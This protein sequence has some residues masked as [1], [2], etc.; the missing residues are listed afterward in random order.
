MKTQKQI[1]QESAQN[2]GVVAQSNSDL[3][4]L[5]NY[6]KDAST[7]YES[8]EF[9]AFKEL[10]RR[11]ETELQI[12]INSSTEIANIMNFLEGYEHEEF[13]TIYLRKNNSIIKKTQQSK[14]GTS[15]TV[16]DTRL[17]LKEAIL[18][19]SSAIILCHNH[20]SGELSPSEADKAITQKIKN[21]AKLM[22][23]VV[24][25]HIIIGGK[26]D[27]YSFADNGLMLM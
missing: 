4:K 23:I 18:L 15:G 25:D 19:N 1:L 14:G 5:I 7:F 13:W 27:Y 20:P 10:L 24:L 22:D 21:S 12:K 11:R 16:V 8:L 9:K 6:K 26:G 2:Y 3:M 17:I